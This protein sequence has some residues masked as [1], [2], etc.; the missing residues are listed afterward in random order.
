M[1]I[2]FY[3][4]LCVSV[5]SVRLSVFRSR[6]A[7]VGLPGTV[8]AHESVGGVPESVW[9]KVQ[10]VKQGGGG[11]DELKAKVCVCVCRHWDL[12]FSRVILLE[13]T[14]KQTNHRYDT[15]VSFFDCA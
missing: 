9:N 10:A 1:F 12:F 4:L 13:P 2:L 8:E 11:L 5:S 15:A 14:E 7:K 3:I 6:R